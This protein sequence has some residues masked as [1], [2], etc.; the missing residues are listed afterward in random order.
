MKMADKIIMINELPYIIKELK[1][2][3]MKKLWPY[4]QP[5]DTS[6]SDIM[7]DVLEESDKILTICL[8]ENYPEIT[9]DFVEK[10]A[11]FVEVNDAIEVLRN[12]IHDAITKKKTPAVNQEIQMDLQLENQNGTGEKSTQ[13]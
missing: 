10:N 4:I 5:K 1:F 2:G 8:Q 12:M 13:D 11:G 9:D 7:N 6:K 3:V